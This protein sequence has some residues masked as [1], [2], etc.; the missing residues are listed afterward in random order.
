ML[1]QCLF[2]IAQA[3]HPLS[4]QERFEVDACADDPPI[5]VVQPGSGVEHEVAEIGLVRSLQVVDAPLQVDL[6]VGEVDG[7]GEFP[8]CAGSDTFAR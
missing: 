4:E 5:E 7:L 8:R 1:V 2:L 6:Q 3:R